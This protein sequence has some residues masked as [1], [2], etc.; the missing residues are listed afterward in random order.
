[1]FQAFV[2]DVVLV[3]WARVKAACSVRSDKT[4]S[5]PMGKLP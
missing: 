4:A 3:F 1:L 5:V 2:I